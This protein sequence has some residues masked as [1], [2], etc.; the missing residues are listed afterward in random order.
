MPQPPKKRL[1]TIK[2]KGGVIEGEVISGDAAVRA[3]AAVPGS[4]AATNSRSVLI[5]AGVATS[6]RAAAD[7]RARR[8]KAIAAYSRNECLKPG[9]QSRGCT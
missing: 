7:T 6:L 5:T 8:C 1:P 3:T 2:V 9:R 4:S